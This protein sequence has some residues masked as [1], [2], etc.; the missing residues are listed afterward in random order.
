LAKPKISCGLEC[1]E[2]HPWQAGT[3]A[4]GS[5]PKK[6]LFGTY[7]LEPLDPLKLLKIKRMTKRIQADWGF[8]KRI[9][10]G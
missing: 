3:S 4:G 6:A 1:K 10:C 9:G 2:V 5:L 8:F 7:P